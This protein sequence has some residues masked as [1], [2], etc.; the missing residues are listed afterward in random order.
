MM[1]I[2]ASRCILPFAS[3]SP[4]CNLN[5]FRK[6]YH[7]GIMANDLSSQF[8]AAIQLANSGRKTEALTQL[9]RLLIQ[10]PDNIPGLMWLSGLTP[11]PHEGIAALEKVLSLN[12]EPSVAQRAQKGL[13]AL[14]AKINASVENVPSTPPAPVTLPATPVVVTT[15]I[16]TPVPPVPNPIA[17]ARAVIWPFRKL[18]R[19]M[20]ELLDSGKITLKDLKWAA[21]P[22]SYAK[23]DVRHAA[24]VLI[25]ILEKQETKAIS[26]A[27][28]DQA[29]AEAL[30]EAR[31]VIWPYRHMHRPMGEL[32]DEGKI[33]DKDLRYAA[34]QGHASLRLAAIILLK[35][36]SAPPPVAGEAVEAT[37]AVEMSLAEAQ[38]VPWPFNKNRLNQRP[39]GQLLAEGKIAIKDLRYAVDHA[40]DD[41][42][43]EA[44]QVL[45]DQQSTEA[46]IKAEATGE[47]DEGMVKPVEFRPTITPLG[48]GS[49]IVLGSSNYLAQGKLIGRLK[50]LAGL[51]FSDDLLNEGMRDYSAFK[52]GER[53]EEEVVAE[54]KRLLDRRWKLFRNVVV[55]GSDA[56]I[57][58]VLVGPTGVLAF[59][60]KAY[61][62]NFRVRGSQWHY[63]A[64]GGWRPVDVNPIK[65][66]AWNRQ[67]LARY[68]NDK[69]RNDEIP[70]SVMIVLGR[71]P[72]NIQLF[73]PSVY[74]VP[75]LGLLERSLTSYLAQPALPNHTVQVVMHTIEMITA[76]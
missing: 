10:Q 5:I 76:H 12:P 75:R 63:R 21:R 47:L 18:N 72:Q 62:G 50:A 34:Q 35:G 24:Q 61:S 19:P 59:E 33:T 31:A 20:G 6:D 7:P 9:R 17:E 53:G 56:D 73:K 52:K 27:M 16:E 55:P 74:I 14:Q 46:A 4:L 25:P 13:A 66:A 57:D 68:L 40:K 45:L 29:F 43:V 51:L 28:P 54:L 71:E 23:D 41:A 8:G 38:A 65:Q 11:D 36:L 32:L 60:I 70:I 64:S 42:V 22:T 3:V 67:R 37:A 26:T 39:M 48:D 30:T 2:V 69:H 15:A 58:A 44:A 1:H 49:L